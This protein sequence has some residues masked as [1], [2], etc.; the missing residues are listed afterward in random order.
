VRDKYNPLIWDK[1]QIYVSGSLSI[2]LYLLFRLQFGFDLTD[3]SW[4]AASNEVGFNRGMPYGFSLIWHPVMSLLNGNLLAARFLFLTLSFLSIYCLSIFIVKY[5]IHRNL[6]A[7]NINWNRERLTQSKAEYFFYGSLGVLLTYCYFPPAIGY[8]QSTFLF[9]CLLISIIL[10]IFSSKHL[11][12]LHLISLSILTSFLIVLIFLSKFSAGIISLFL[13]MLALFI[14]R[15]TL[16][17][18]LIFGFTLSLFISFF[19]LNTDFAN[20]ISEIYQVVI[21]PIRAEHFAHSTSSLLGKYFFDFIYFVISA[22]S[23]KCFNSAF[24]RKETIK[25]N[26]VE[27]KFWVNI[28]ASV[29]LLVFSFYL[30]E[31]RNIGFPVKYLYMLFFV[32]VLFGIIFALL[33]PGKNRKIKKDGSERFDTLVVIF[34]CIVIGQVFGTNNGLWGNLVYYA[35]TILILIIYLMNSKETLTISKVS[36]RFTR[37]LIVSITL[38]MT[39][40]IGILSP[41]RIAPISEQTQNISSGNLAGIK[42]D[43]KTLNELREIEKAIEFSKLAGVNKLFAIDAPALAIFDSKIA[44]QPLWLTRPW[45]ITPD[46]IIEEC[47]NSPQS[48]L[49]NYSLYSLEGFPDWPQ[50]NDALNV[51]GLIPVPV[52]PTITL[53]RQKKPNYFDNLVCNKDLVLD[54]R[55]LGQGWWPSSGAP[56]W[57]TEGFIEVYLPKNSQNGTFQL[58]YEKFSPLV[59]VD[60][61][62]KSR[63][64][65]SL[66]IEGEKIKILV[67][68]S[69][70]PH[71]I[72][73]YIE[74]AVRPKNVSSSEDVRPLG[75]ALKQLTYVCQR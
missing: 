46:L 17:L 66:V 63:H 12:I 51:C 36:K 47:L 28:V 20:Y 13:T 30:M 55:I 35:P 71:K 48:D 73:L 59:K 38:W 50:L 58:S 69:N 61:R 2:Y 27:K 34:V 72:S 41:Y 75:I 7:S 49:I 42:V 4:I 22:I 11:R 56:Y 62:G 31:S 9:S 3:E 43:K 21:D 44:A 37:F 39:F 23:I 52:S 19:Y 26:L 16:V 53:L 54:N 14:Y 45:A 6:Q 74:N 18:I 10:K 25:E 64:I 68:G 70:E 33:F 5:Q 29:S 15:Q 32:M 1:T 24:N 65:Q 67:A 8:N 57:S 40:Y 60:V